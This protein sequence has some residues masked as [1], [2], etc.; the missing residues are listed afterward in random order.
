LEGPNAL[1]TGTAGRD[2]P[3]GRPRRAQRSR[4]TLFVKS[5]RLYKSPHNI[6]EGRVAFRIPPKLV[7]RRTLTFEHAF[8][9]DKVWRRPNLAVRVC[10]QLRPDKIRCIGRMFQNQKDSGA[11]HDRLHEDLIPH[12]HAPGY[13]ESRPCA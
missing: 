3:L 1:V 10:P 5:A 7:H 6:T 11:R 12:I 8:K 13:F 2:G 9:P 4:P